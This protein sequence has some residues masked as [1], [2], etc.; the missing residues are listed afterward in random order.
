MNTVTAVQA[1]AMM[2][3][4]VLQMV[5]LYI[6]ESWVMMEAV[7]KVLKGFHHQVDLR[8][9]EMSDRRV[10][11]KGWGWSLVAEALEAVGLWTMKE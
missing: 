9:E 4:V 8:I 11:E 10:G 2:Y 1:R 7:L 5:S 6:S 3:N